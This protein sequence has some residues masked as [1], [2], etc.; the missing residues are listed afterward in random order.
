VTIQKAHGFALL[1]LIFVCGIIGIISSIAVPRMILARQS[2]SAASA[3]GTLRTIN[4]AELTFA[5]TCGSGFYAPDLPT[6]GVAP[7]GSIQ[8]FVG[9]DLGAAATVT[10]SSYQYQLSGVAFA[11][12]PGTCNGLA[13]GAAGR[14]YR[15]AADPLDTT[16][17][18]FFATNASGTLWEDTATM[19]AAMPEYDDPPSGHPLR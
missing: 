13:P 8:G 18:R 5:V 9:P 11:G 2:A 19:F 12:A 3:I 10:K 17:S 15:A 7:P 4:S 6:L 16:N 14:G 1:D